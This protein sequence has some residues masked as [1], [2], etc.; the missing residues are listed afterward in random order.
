VPQPPPDEEPPAPDSYSLAELQRLAHHQPAF[1][2]NMLRLF[3]SGAEEHLRAMEAALQAGDWDEVSMRAHRLAPPCRHLGL[4]SLVD[5]LKQVE[6]QA[7]DRVEPG[8]IA[9][10]VQDCAQRLRRVLVQVHQDLA[11]L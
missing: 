2:A 3:A 8:S 10:L 11:A 4:H 6:I 1:V 9:G 5:R 7:R